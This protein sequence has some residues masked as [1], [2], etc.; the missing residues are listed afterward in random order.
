MSPYLTRPRKGPYGYVVG[1]L[2][3]DEP[4]VFA[5]GELQNAE[6][7]DFPV[8][9]EAV[10]GLNRG[11]E[12]DAA[13]GER[14]AAAARDLESRGVRALIGA[15]ASL[16]AFQREVAQAVRVPVMLSSLLQL[17]LIDHVLP[18][19]RAIGV[20]A[21]DEAAAR[22]AI[23]DQRL[24]P[25]RRAIAV[26]GVEAPA[27]GDAAGL[28]ERT[29]AAARALCAREP[30]IGGIVLEGGRMCRHARAVHDATGL[31]V[32][33]ALSMTRFLKAGARQDSYSGY[34]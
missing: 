5:P 11:P 24:T 9:Y 34:Y 13:L 14:V 6:S 23:S 7:F 19:G 16:L 31:P 33:D 29:V 12:A 17:P 20:L 26:S 28:K 27:G 15:D 1:V 25:H 8:L 3:S 22:R 4:G 18:A 32:F 10:T 21:V 2:T 30:D